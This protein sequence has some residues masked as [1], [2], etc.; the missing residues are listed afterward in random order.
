M[1]LCSFF[2][3]SNVQIYTEAST[4]ISESDNLGGPAQAELQTV[5]TFLVVCRLSMAN[6]KVQ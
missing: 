6:R 5:S 2:I 3:I 4:H 1:P